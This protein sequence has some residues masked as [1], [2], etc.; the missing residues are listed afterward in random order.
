MRPKHRRYSSFDEPDYGRD[1]RIFAFSLAIG[2]CVG[3]FATYFWMAVQAPASVPDMAQ[4]QVAFQAV[5][6]R[7]QRCQNEA[8]RLRGGE[9]ELESRLS[10]CSSD[11]RRARQLIEQAVVSPQKIESSSAPPAQSASAVAPAPQAQS[12][13]AAWPKGWPPKPA[14]KPVSVRSL[15][16]SIQAADPGDAAD[17]VP[18]SAGAP[19]APQAP[20][21]QAQSLTLD[22]GS[23]VTQEGYVVRLIGVSKRTSGSY[24]VIGGNGIVGQRV[25]SGTTRQVKWGS[26]TVSLTARVQDRDTCRITL[27]PR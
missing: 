14:L 6:D 2:L 22:V 25:A 26:Y 3:A 7:L 15:I 23:E 12:A 16:S 18:R 9:D 17:N 19:G 10:T 11:L 21:R 1:W 24:C 8:N 5:S 4:Q 13:A 27:A 20:L